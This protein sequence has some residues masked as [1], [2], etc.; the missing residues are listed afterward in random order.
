[1]HNRTC[2]CRLLTNSVLLGD[3][4]HHKGIRVEALRISCKDHEENV[5]FFCD[6]AYTDQDGLRNWLLRLHLRLL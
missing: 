3:L 4:A 1:M 5:L 6:G 2:G